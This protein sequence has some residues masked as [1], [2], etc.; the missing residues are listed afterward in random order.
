[1]G[2][3]EAPIRE[4]HIELLEREDVLALQRRKLAALGLRLA[5]SPDWKA[6]LGAARVDG[7]DLADPTQFAALPTME[8]GASGSHRGHIGVRLV[9]SYYCAMGRPGFEADGVANSTTIQA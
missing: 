8:K 3:T 6:F 1:M 4:P 2:P 7:R 9:L 5:A